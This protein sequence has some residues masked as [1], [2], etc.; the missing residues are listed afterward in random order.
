MSEMKYEYGAVQHEGPDRGGAW[1]AFPWNIRQEF[2]RGLLGRL[3]KSDLYKD[4]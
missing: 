1:A 4:G 2:G 3:Q